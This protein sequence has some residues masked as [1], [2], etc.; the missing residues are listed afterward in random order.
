[1][2]TC[3]PHCHGDIVK[4]NKRSRN[5]II[6]H[7]LG[8]FGQEFQITLTGNRKQ[9]KN[10]DDC[11]KKSTFAPM[12]FR[13]KA[14]YPLLTLGLLP[15]GVEAQEV[16]GL[17]QTYELQASASNHHTPLWL[18]AN[19]YGLSSLRAGNGYLRGSLSYNADPSNGRY[20]HEDEDLDHTWGWNA[21]ADIVVPVAGYRYKNYTT[22]DSYHQRLILQQCYVKGRYKHGVLTLGARQQP[23]ELKN[24]ELSSGSQTLG[25]NARPIPQVRLATDDFWTIPYTRNWLSFKGHISYGVMTDGLWEEKWAKDTRH[26]YN[27]W[28]RYH[29]KAGYLRIGNPLRTPFSL[30][31]GLE[32]AA[33]FGGTLHNWSGTDQ[34]GNISLDKV[35]LNNGLKSYWNAF[36][37]G[38]EDTGDSQFKNAEGNQLGSWVARM[39]F[40]YETWGFGIYADHFFEDHS[41]MFFLDYDGYG[42][43]AEWD[44]K[45]K[46][47]FF[48]YNP[49]DIQLGLDL[50]FKYFKYLKDFVFEFINTKYQSGPIYHDHNQSNP[51]HLGGADKYYNHSRLS[52]WQHW[53]QVIGNP[54]YRSPQYNDDGYIGVENNRFTAWHLA[55]AGDPTEQ[56][57]YRVKASWQKGW[58]TYEAPYLRRK[59]NMSLLFEAAYAMPEA[60]WLEGLEVQ[61]AWGADF[62]E[63]LGDNNGFQLTVRYRL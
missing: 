54:L 13:I 46:T 38:G 45:K 48:L 22:G 26:K 18:N 49:E 58:G 40:K 57:H 3:R 8:K 43:G 20:D 41:S 6:A 4:T 10:L 9:K 36:I 29:E 44:K 61:L 42:T 5:G 11:E 30:T 14:A 31:L 1:M 53:G 17:R 27:K 2:E 16:E 15:L 51:D 28:T 34:N 23:M 55:F 25:I 37:P 35:K 7:R 19:K 12:K 62:G 33:Q 56:L 47:K 59:D 39:D 50:H 21:G 32:M 60:S 63:I 24:N 52:G